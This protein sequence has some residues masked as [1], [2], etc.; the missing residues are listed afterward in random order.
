MMILIAFCDNT[1]FSTKKPRKS[2]EIE[3]KKKNIARFSTT[4]LIEGGGGGGSAGTVS[5]SE[6]L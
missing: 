6:Q 4:F 1:H 5:A 3:K 2:V